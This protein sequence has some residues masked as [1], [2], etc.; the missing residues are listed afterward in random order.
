MGSSFLRKELAPA[1]ALWTF[2]LNFI[3]TLNSQKVRF[4]GKLATASERVPVHTDIDT[5]LGEMMTQTTEIAIPRRN[6]SSGD[7]EEGH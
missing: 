7:D 3:F 1:V 6:N 2:L 4:F 5:P